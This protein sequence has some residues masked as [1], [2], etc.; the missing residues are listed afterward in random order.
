[1]H[2]TKTSEL[3]RIKS[4]YTSLSKLGVVTKAIDATNTFTDNILPF[5]LYRNTRNH[6]KSICDQINSSYHYQIYDGCLV[7]MRKLIE[8]LL[9]ISICKVGEESLI[10][11]TNGNYMQLSLITSFAKDSS[12]LSLS[13]NCKES[14]SRLVEKGNL[15]AHNPMFIAHKR[16]IDNDQLA[17]RQI[18]EEL[19]HK[20]S[21]I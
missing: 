11:D 4:L 1:M 14:L 12:N 13:R 5:T 17:F 15:S 18:A 20:G 16:D 21:I 3:L 10:K 9:I 2:K 8:S 19:M 6:I 7:L